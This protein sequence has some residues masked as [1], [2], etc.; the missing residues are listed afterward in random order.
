LIVASG[1]RQARPRHPGISLSS[2]VERLRSE[3]R[4]EQAI[5]RPGTRFL[6]D[7]IQSISDAILIADSDQRYVAVNPAACKLTGYSATEL[8][9]RGLH[10]LTPSA[11]RRAAQRTWP[12]LLRSGVQTADFTLCRKDGSK[13]RVR[14]SAAAHLFP[15]VHI[16]VFRPL[17][18]PR[19]GRD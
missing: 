10:D 1:D 16:A 6:K 5:R 15:G 17:R 9:S 14:Y 12:N 11:E 2:I 19:I 18:R 13:L 4:V 3:A 8:L 7:R